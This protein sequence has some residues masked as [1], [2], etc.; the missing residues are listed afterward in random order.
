MNKNLLLII[1]VLLS[2]NIFIHPA[3]DGGVP[4]GKSFDPIDHTDSAA[5]ILAAD[6]ASQEPTLSEDCELTAEQSAIELASQPGPLQEQCDDHLWSIA[7]FLEEKDLRALQ[8]TCKK[9]NRVIK[10]LRQYILRKHCLP[11]D[12]L[13]H[14]FSFLPHP[15]FEAFQL[16]S[17]KTTKVGD[18]IRASR[19]RKLDNNSKENLFVRALTARYKRVM[20]QLVKAG[21]SINDDMRFPDNSFKTPLE[22]A[23]HKAPIDIVRFLISIGADVNQRERDSSGYSVL[24]NAIWKMKDLLKKNKIIRLLLDHGADVN[25]SSYDGVTPLMLSVYNHQ[26]IVEL[27]L[28]YNANVNLSD[29]SSRSAL[30]MCACAGD[31]TSAK[32]LLSHGAD[33]DFTNTDG[34]TALNL[35]I[36][37]NYIEIAQSLLDHGART[38]IPNHIGQTA[39]DAATYW[40]RHE[41]IQMLHKHAERRQEG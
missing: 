39:L 3:D 9:S 24:F 5:V 13:G 28:E 12:C 17:Q 19:Y 31:P 26:P 23:I 36:I 33:P 14:I 6:S 34:N 35:A 37:Y 20:R 27:L 1:S 32:L 18:M 41:I 38:D 21:I 40:N 15:D 8:S 29:H 16:T 11:T 10:Q 2:T 22:W 4:E 25:L 7:T 30:L